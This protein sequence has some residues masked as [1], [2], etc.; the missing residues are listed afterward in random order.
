[1][2]LTSQMDRYIDTL[3]QKIIFIKENTTQFQLDMLLSQFKFFLCTGNKNKMIEI[4]N[5]FNKLKRYNEIKSS[6]R[7]V[8]FSSDIYNLIFNKISISLLNDIV[9]SDEN[10]SSFIGNSFIKV[11]NNNHLIGSNDVLLSEDSGFTV[12]TFNVPGI[13]SARFYDENKSIYDEY[14][15]TT[16]IGDQ[17]LRDYIAELEACNISTKHLKNNLTLIAY[18]RKNTKNY[19]PMSSHFATSF[20]L[21][22][23]S[24]TLYNYHEL[25]G[26]IQ[27]KPLTAEYLDSMINSFGYNPLFN[28]VE[29]KDGFINFT[30]IKK[31]TNNTIYFLDHREMAFIDIIVD[32]IL[33]KILNIK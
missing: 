31:D 17:L 15:N 4:T 6:S 13:K 22:H 3:E 1:M 24:K 20:T 11:C 16:Y 23:N 2:I 5:L 12:D 10:S 14:I 7:V 27:V 28:V 8:N 26:F 32:F 33:S 25:T 9:D 30:D 19:T 21:M 18:I 29:L